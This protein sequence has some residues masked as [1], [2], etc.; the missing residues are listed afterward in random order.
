MTTAN[1][2]AR[3]HKAVGWCERCGDKYLL[4]ELVYDGQFPDLL[5]CRPC[6]DPKH[7]QEYLPDVKD[8]VTLYDPTGDLDRAV[9]NQ[10]TV[11]LPMLYFE[12]SPVTHAAR[13]GVTTSAAIKHTIT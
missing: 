3:G 9:A 4:K 6:Y 11:E 7:P 1:K 13:Y 2:Y 5:V 10:I 12:V 8:P